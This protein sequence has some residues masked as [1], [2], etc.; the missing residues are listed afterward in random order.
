MFL[1]LVLKT[2]QSLRSSANKHT[3]VSEG[4]DNRKGQHESNRKIET[5]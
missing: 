2:L 3:R 5:K 1:L 4:V